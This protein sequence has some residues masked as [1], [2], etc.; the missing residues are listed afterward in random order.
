MQQQ[1]NIESCFCL[2]VQLCYLY[3]FKHIVRWV[4][5]CICNIR[6]VFGL[7]RL[8]CNTMASH[9]SSDECADMGWVLSSIS[10]TET[11]KSLFSESNPEPWERFLQLLNYSC[12]AITTGVDQRHY[13]V[14]AQYMQDRAQG[15][16]YNLQKE[17][18]KGHARSD[19]H[20]HQHQR[21]I[22]IIVSTCQLLVWSLRVH[23]RVIGVIFGSSGHLVGL[24]LESSRIHLWSHEVRLLG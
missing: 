15:K 23:I 7:A 22:I 9:V 21:S 17:I 20:Q 2:V 8:S 16:C 12:T 5:G 13:D 24:I 1:Q 19:W 11:K 4:R 3:I 6:L 18:D 10:S 14:A